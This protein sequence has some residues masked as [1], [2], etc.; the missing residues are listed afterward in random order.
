LE[1]RLSPDDGHTGVA[2]GEDHL[3]E[4]VVRDLKRVD[5]IDTL[6]SKH[7]PS[8]PVNVAVVNDLCGEEHLF[9][10]GQRAVTVQEEV[11]HRRTGEV[12]CMRIREAS[13][14]SERKRHDRVPPRCKRR[15]DVEE[16]SLRSPGREK[17]IVR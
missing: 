17:P 11:A 5:D 6:L 2:R 4:Q 15:H 3:R 12:T 13:L 14:V 9:A 10:K 7:V 8:G 16:V 1:I